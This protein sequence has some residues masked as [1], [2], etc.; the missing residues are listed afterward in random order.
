MGASRGQILLKALRYKLTMLEERQKHTFP[1]RFRFA[2]IKEAI[3]NMQ[4]GVLLSFCSA[5]L[6]LQTPTCETGK[7]LNTRLPAA[8][9]CMA[10]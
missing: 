9:D 4:L 1:L 7:W 6:K 8:S 2:G 10:D 5:D 3:S